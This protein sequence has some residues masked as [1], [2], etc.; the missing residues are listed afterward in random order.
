MIELIGVSYR[1]FCESRI[2]STIKNMLSTPLV[3][4]PAVVISTGNFFFFNHLPLNFSPLCSFSSSI[5]SLIT[6]PQK[7][8]YFM[9]IFR[10]IHVSSNPATCGLALFM[11]RMEHRIHCSVFSSRLLGSLLPLSHN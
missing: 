5:S 9:W 2:S 4:E 10:F 11:R 6:I 1:V 3:Y 7:F 8:I